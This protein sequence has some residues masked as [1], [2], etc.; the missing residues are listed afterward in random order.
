MA[1]RL[2]G[3]IISFKVNGKKYDARGDFKYSLGNPTREAIVGEDG[4]HGFKEMPVAP[5]ISGTITDNQ[6]LDVAT[7]Q[8]VSD[9]T[10]TLALKN[11]KTIIL[12]EGFFA[13]ESEIEAAEGKIPFKF[14]GIECS[15]VS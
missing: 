6:D 9:A 14:S 13:G 3:G 15:E 4:V 11:G 1:N 10:V 12:S 7:L 2:V 5:Y 8:K